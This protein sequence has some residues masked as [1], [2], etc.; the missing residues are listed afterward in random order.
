MVRGW[1]RSFAAPSA[2]L[3]MLSACGGSGGGLGGG[4]TII[5]NPPTTPPNNFTQAAFTCPASLTSFSASRS[6][7]AMA[8]PR[9]GV[10]RNR[11]APT[12]SDTLLVVSY[13]AGAANRQ[14][15]DS[16]IT[17][18]GATAVGDLAFS[19]LGRAARVVRVTPA[20]LASTQNALRAVP[21]VT[22]VSPSRRL[23]AQTVSAPYFTND[24][25]FDGLPG[26][27][28][29]LYQT[30]NTGGQWDMHVVGL[31]HAFAYSQPGNGSGITNAGALGSTSVRLAVVDTGTDL[32]H[33]DLSGASVIR[34][35]CF[36]TDPNNSLSTGTF[37]TD[38][39][40]HGT[41]VTGIAAA[42]SGNGYGFTGD[43]GNVSL[44]LYRVFPT[45]DDNCASPSSQAAAND[46]QCGAADLDIASAINDA[47]AN[48]ANVINL[49]MGLG[50]NSST[51]TCS[52]GQDPD[53][54]EGNAV[55]NA[56]ASNVIV[57]AS[58]GNDGANAI[59]APACD[60]GVIAA[61]ASA[62][63]DGQP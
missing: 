20:T 50:V 36:L 47:V 43:A 41:D 24:P 49:S 13:A 28:A 11:V 31:E 30:A 10:V 29:P 54:I 34:T 4:T 3:I 9:R 15:L 39:T 21:G 35:R 16:R 23:Y 42:V 1:L 25:Y 59:S 44:M 55:A 40:G 51:P 33:P 56:V 45:P 22:D 63:N 38:P 60:S 5:N 2:A 32:T 8:E 57:V 62:Y 53:S 7:S 26:A 18:L 14:A 27:S 17:S 58:S 48:G 61:G 19:R 12:P 46:P 37:V 52:N 6:A